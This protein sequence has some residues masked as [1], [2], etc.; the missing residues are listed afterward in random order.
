MIH[1]AQPSNPYSSW[2]MYYQA[3]L[4]LRTVRLIIVFTL[5]MLLVLAFSSS[6]SNRKSWIIGTSGFSVDR[7]LFWQWR[8][9]MRR[10]PT[11]THTHS[12]TRAHNTNALTQDERLMISRRVLNSAHR[13]L[14]RN[15]NRKCNYVSLW[16]TVP[17]S[18][19]WFMRTRLFACVWIYLEHRE[20]KRRRACC[21]SLQ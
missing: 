14:I 16:P 4:R 17:L 20:R 9:S 12:K 8:V 21:F 10:G 11:H 7:C 15:C 1:V 13:R 2:I 5:H 6:S 19:V 3:R 18:V